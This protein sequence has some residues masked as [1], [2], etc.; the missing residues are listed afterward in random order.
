MQNKTRLAFAMIAIMIGVTLFISNRKTSDLR[1]FVDGDTAVLSGVTNKISY[2]EMKRFLRKNP[3][4]EHLVLGD[5]PGT[6]NSASNLRIA[7]LIRKNGLTTHLRRDSRIASGAVDLFISGTKR[8]M[9]CGALIGVHSWGLPGNL[10][11]NDMG[12][13]D[14]RSIHEKFLKDMGV[15]PSFYVFT[16]DAAEPE[17]I[18]VLKSD[19]IIRFG[20]LTKP[21]NCGPSVEI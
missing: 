18:Y 16:R 7:R 19:E 14:S 17:E 12:R 11:P 20:L 8:T 10:S 9:E 15:D 4:I 21:S 6:V 1:I 3:Q 13:D 2:R 5:M